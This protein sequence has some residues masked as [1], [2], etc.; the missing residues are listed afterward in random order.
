MAPRPLGWRREAESDRAEERYPYS[1]PTPQVVER[2]LKLP[3][4][5]RTHDQGLEGSCVG[6]AVALERAITNTAQLR[7]LGNRYG[8]R[9]YDPIGLW[10]AA[11]SIDEWSYTKPEDDHGT[12][13]RAAYEIARTRGLAR[14]RSMRLVDGRPTPSGPA[15]VDL[16]AGVMEYRWTRTVDGIRAAIA[17]GL[18]VAIGVQWFT[19]FDAPVLRPSGR[20][21]RAERWT[22]SVLGRVRGGHSVALAGASDRRQAFLLVNSWGAEYPPAWLPYETMGR[23]LAARGEAALVTDL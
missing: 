21:G 12:S 13:V 15:A 14:V 20:R 16:Y 1:A 22:P 18:P 10:R 6:H 4:W 7:A 23:L 8:W 9:R 19:G 11:K 5:L 17:A 3:G 2:T